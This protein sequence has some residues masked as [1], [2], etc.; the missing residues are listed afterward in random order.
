MNINV[1][2]QKSTGLKKPAPPQAASV[3][4]SPC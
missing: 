4:G 1:K 2:R 3:N